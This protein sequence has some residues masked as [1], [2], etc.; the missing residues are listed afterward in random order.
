MVPILV[1]SSK[2]IFQEYA[3]HFNE[4]Y[5]VI[6]NIKDHKDSDLLYR[7]LSLY[8]KYCSAYTLSKANEKYLTSELV[9]EKDCRRISASLQRRA[10]EEVQKEC[11]TLLDKSAVADKS[12][13]IELFW[14]KPSF[15]LNKVIEEVPKIEFKFNVNLLNH[16][17]S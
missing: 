17:A 2:A 12:V 7:I 1:L 9:G 14:K 11:Q 8:Q 15:P 3:I 16:P 6:R 13:G 5:L 10:F 4:P